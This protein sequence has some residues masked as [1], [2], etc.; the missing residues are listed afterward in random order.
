MSGLT[1]SDD[2]AEKLIAAYRT[3]DLV[4]QRKATLQR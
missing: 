2:A 3:P 4:Q 1:F